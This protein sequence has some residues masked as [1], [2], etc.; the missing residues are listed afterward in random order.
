MSLSPLLADANIYWHLPF[1]ILIVSL[2][3]SATKYDR[4]D[5][6]LREAFRW[7]LRMILFLAG[8][9]LILLGLALDESGLALRAGLVIVG[10]GV[11]VGLL[12][13]K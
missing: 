12:F 11:E 1:L 2:V 5:Y 8:I 10:V 6:I 3:Y 7:A 4:W 9:V 13:I